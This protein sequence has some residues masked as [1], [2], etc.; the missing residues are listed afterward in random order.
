MSVQY[1]VVP[2]GAWLQ[3]YSDAWSLFKQHALQWV[4]MML[5]FMLLSLLV[6]IIPLVG[7]AVVSLFSPVLL[8]GMMLAAQ[9]VD[10]G[11]SIGVADLFSVFKEPLRRKRLI[12]VGALGLLMVL[13]NM[14]IMAL[15]MGGVMSL[16]Q[17][18]EIGP[19]SLIGMLVGMLAIS[20]LGFLWS[21]ALFFG[22]PLLALEDIEPVAALKS[23]LKACL[24]NWLSLTLYGL[25]SVIV[26]FVAII[27]FGLGLLV[28][29]PFLICTLYTAYVSIYGV[30]DRSVIISASS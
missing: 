23:S 13:L 1:T 2:A 14:L 21:M 9:K 18:G 11:Q 26:V 29:L 22:L 8:G 4:L 12:I 24:R 25:A 16:A 15:Y 10:A 5:A 20:G 7:V 6:S 3:W 19:G 30:S 27:P 28:A 17:I